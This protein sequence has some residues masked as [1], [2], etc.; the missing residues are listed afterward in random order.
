MKR[1]RV[2][3]TVILLL[4]VTN[5]ATYSLATG[6]IP[7]I[8]YRWGVGSFHVGSAA[9]SARLRD[10][11]NL[12]MSN[13]VD[14]VDG[15]ALIEGALKGMADAVGDPYT[16]YMDPKEFQEFD[17]SLSGEYEGVGMVV[18][19]IGDYVTVV[20][21]M[22]GSPA[23]KAGILPRDR[24]V[25]VD[26]KDVVK[27]PSDVVAGL[28]RGKEGTTVT[29]TVARGD[30][31]N[32][33]RL[34]FKLTR[35]K[36]VIESASGKMLFPNEGIGYISITEFSEKTPAQFSAALAALR[37]QGLKALVLDLRGNPGGYL[38]ECVT[39]AQSFVTSG[40]ILHRVGRDGKDNVVNAAGGPPLGVPLVVLVDGGTA[41]AAEILAGAI[42]DH[43]VG[44]LVGV[45]TYGKGTV[46]TPY[47][48]GGGSY[49]RLTTE[50][51]LTPNGD[52]ITG[53]GITPD[54]IVKLP[55]IGANEPP[56]SLSDPND[57]RDTQLR[58]AIEILR[59][60]LGT[61]SQGPTARS[62]PARGPA[63][64]AAAIPAATAAVPAATA[65]A[66]PAA[67]AT[68]TAATVGSGA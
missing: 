63:A 28:I 26:G 30:P 34:D 2:V 49:L 3:L 66:I 53:K 19:T 43:K 68:L 39:I 37:A 14:P 16:Y 65:A 41:S 51:W 56:L 40:A 64:T 46:Q 7:W 57:P 25:A 18:E 31:S 52:Q 47:D 15:H 21:P 10:E 60:A 13:Y 50:R 17:I 22:R 67:T 12:I 33:T 27:V 36:I 23:E 6:V 32:E 38:E 45:T 5:V 59:A 58:R 4:L 42:K 11:Y 29:I 9:D 24:I 62:A 55:K 8:N 35:A 61:G 48:L 44:T 1:N 20:S 54:E